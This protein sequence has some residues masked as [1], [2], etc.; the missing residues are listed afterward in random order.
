MPK[1]SYILAA[2][3]TAVW[4]QGTNPY[5]IAKASGIPLTTVQRLLSRKTSLPLRN[6]EALLD[7]LG[8]RVVL[9]Q[10]GKT[11]V[12]PAL[13]RGPGKARKIRK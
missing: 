10:G 4:Q 13:N 3:R 2:I 1:P 7:A 8:V 9:L 5:Q 6:V 11:K 12:P